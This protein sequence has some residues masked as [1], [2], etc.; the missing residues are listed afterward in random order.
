MRTFN[1]L[2]ISDS[3]A[4]KSAEIAAKDPHGFIITLTS[5]LVVFAALIILYFAYTWIGKLLSDK[6]E[7]KVVKDRMA[8]VDDE[9]AAV[10]GLALEQY[11]NENAHDLESY[12]ITIKRK[13]R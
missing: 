5:V 8:E 13:N 12:T 9:I 1:L 7:K 4:Q 11:L 6:S 3:V 10:I 2:Q